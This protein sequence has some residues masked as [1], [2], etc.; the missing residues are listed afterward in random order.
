MAMAVVAMRE[1]LAALGGVATFACRFNMLLSLGAN[2][3][4]HSL[5]PWQYLKSCGAGLTS[6]LWSGLGWREGEN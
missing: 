2:T 5:G 3:M 1:C 6:V 4:R